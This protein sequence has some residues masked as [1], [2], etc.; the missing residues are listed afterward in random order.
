MPIIDVI[1]L[2]INSTTAIATVVAIPATIVYSAR[3]MK[4]T[5]ARDDERR[6]YAFTRPCSNKLHELMFGS[7]RLLGTTIRSKGQTNT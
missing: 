7:P 6:N 3:Q 2:I 5:F 4:M 1:N